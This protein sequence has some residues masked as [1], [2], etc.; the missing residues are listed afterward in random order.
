MPHDQ[1]EKKKTEHKQRKRYCNKFNR[2]FKNGPPQKNLKKIK[3]C[4][5]KT[6]ACFITIGNRR[7]LNFITKRHLSTKFMLGLMMTNTQGL[8]HERF[9]LCFPSISV[10][11][12]C[13]F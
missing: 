11:N 13:I 9:G 4:A 6:R 7:N 10:L 1:E 3:L 5:F 2:D 8:T 12:L